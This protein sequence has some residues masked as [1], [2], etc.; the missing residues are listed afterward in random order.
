MYILL[1]SQLRHTYSIT[2]TYDIIPSPY[3]PPQ[4]VPCEKTSQYL[5]HSPEITVWSV[6]TMSVYLIAYYG[7]NIALN[8]ACTGVCSRTLRFATE[9]TTGGEEA[10][11]ECSTQCTHLL[12]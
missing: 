2:V 10:S 8:A 5:L 4:C 12:L 1:P 3:L 7:S 11:G 9:D 6:L